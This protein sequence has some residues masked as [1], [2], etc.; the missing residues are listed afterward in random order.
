M[1]VEDVNDRSMWDAE[2]V[3][4]HG[5]LASIVKNYESTTLQHVQPY[6][7]IVQLKK[8]SLHISFIDFMESSHSLKITDFSI[9]RN[10]FKG[11]IYF[12]YILT[13]FI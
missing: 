7:F 10:H 13:V 4:D 3:W 8:G 1:G 5:K 11:F 12:F 6:R 2:M 9:F